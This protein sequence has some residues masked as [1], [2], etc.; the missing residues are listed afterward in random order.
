MNALG[1]EKMYLEGE[2]VF[3]RE[4]ERDHEKKGRRGRTLIL[5]LTKPGKEEETKERVP[6]I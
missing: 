1:E 3:R 4:T 2:R 5:I 6:K